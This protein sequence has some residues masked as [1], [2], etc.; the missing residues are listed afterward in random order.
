ATPS[1]PQEQRAFVRLDFDVP[2]LRADLQEVQLDDDGIVRAMLK[3]E[4]RGDRRLTVRRDMQ[5]RPAQHEALGQDRRQD[6]ERIDAGIEY[7]ESARLEDPI[8]TRMPV[9]NVLFPGRAHG[10]DRPPREPIP[11]RGDSPG[12]A[13]M[14]CPDGRP[15]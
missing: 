13:R 4:L 8:L 14:P 3:L 10:F 12:L 2:A 15:V 9:T 1:L 11:C 6:R 7:A 5:R